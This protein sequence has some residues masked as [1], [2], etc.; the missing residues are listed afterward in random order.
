MGI[1]GCAPSKRPFRP[2]RQDRDTERD[3]RQ[4][5]SILCFWT[6]PSSCIYLMWH[7]PTSQECQ[8][9][10]WYRPRRFTLVPDLVK[11]IPD[12]DDDDD[13][14]TM[15]VPIEPNP[16]SSRVLSSAEGN[17]L[18][19]TNNDRIESREEKRNKR[20]RMNDAKIPSLIERV[21]IIHGEKTT[22]VMPRL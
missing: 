19:Q 22:C 8:R 17:K 5:V 7:W 18:T 9:I 2:I 12:D 13:E 11:T 14:M 6:S 10:V 4:P 15:T 16:I 1:R 3:S 20:E 21:L